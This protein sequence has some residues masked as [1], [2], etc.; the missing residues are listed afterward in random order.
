MATLSGVPSV[1]PTLPGDLISVTVSSASGEA[2][3]Q[4]V[5]VT[6][7]NDSSRQYAFP[8]LID[9][10][11]NSGADSQTVTAE[12]YASGVSDVTVSSPGA[13]GWVCTQVDYDYSVGE[14]IKG[15]ATWVYVESE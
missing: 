3:V 1:G 4:K 12:F 2:S 5:D 14:F 15:S 7:L 11:G 8:P 13:T 10:G 6:T 9:A